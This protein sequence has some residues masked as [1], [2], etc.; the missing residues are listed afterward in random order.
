M[1][2]WKKLWLLFAVIWVVV[3]AI[4]VG[5]ILATSEEPEKALQPLVLGVAVPLALY[6]LGWLWERL[7]K[8][9]R[10][11]NNLRETDRDRSA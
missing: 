10:G 1:A 3:A 7:R 8:P 4:Q 5:V 2:L 6:G 11:Q 9:K